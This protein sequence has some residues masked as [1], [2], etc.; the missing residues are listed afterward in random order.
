MIKY[1]KRAPKGKLKGKPAYCI[2]SHRTH[3]VLSCYR[4]KGQAKK[5]LQRMHIFGYYAKRKKKKK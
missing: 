4:T 5:A 2:V 3:K 1:F